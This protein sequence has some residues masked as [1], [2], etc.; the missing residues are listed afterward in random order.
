MPADP[1]DL[2]AIEARAA[3]AT[4]GPWATS[5]EWSVR[6]GARDDELVA[7]VQYKDHGRDA[8]FIA[9]A[10]SDVPALVAEL[11]ALRAER[12]AAARVVAAARRLLARPHLT[13]RET[14]NALATTTVDRWDADG[15]YA[16]RDAC[17]AHAASYAGEPQPLD[18][19]SDVRAL[20]ALDARGGAAPLL[21]CSACGERV[22]RDVVHDCPTQRSPRAGAAAGGAR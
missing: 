2:D 11:R 10:R 14:C 13:R 17:D 19:A 21:L 3:A 1:L 4:P 9:A 7:C 16:G 22:T 15:C 18:Q 20:A 6:T 12:D 8:E 5:S